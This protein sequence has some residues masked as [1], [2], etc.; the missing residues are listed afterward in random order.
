MLGTLRIRTPGP[1]TR[2]PALS[3]RNCTSADDLLW[4][5]WKNTTL[6][7]SAVII[8]LQRLPSLSCSEHGRSHHKLKIPTFVNLGFGT[9]RNWQQY[10]HPLHS[11]LRSYFFLGIVVTMPPPSLRP[12]RHSLQFIGLHNQTFGLDS[13][14]TT[15]ITIMNVCFLLRLHAKRQSFRNR[16]AATRG[17][18]H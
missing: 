15:F 2:A 12:L 5:L 13:L 18:A 7:W 4:Y 9:A 3:N 6:F 1:P 17:V 14:H 10:P 11:P 8:S 16:F